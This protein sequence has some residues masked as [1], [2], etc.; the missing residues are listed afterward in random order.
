MQVMHLSLRLLAAPLISLLLD[1]VVPEESVMQM[2]SHEVAPEQQVV[3]ESSDRAKRAVHAIEWSPGKAVH[4]K[5]SIDQ[6]QSQATRVSGAA[7]IPGKLLR[8]SGHSTATA[9]VEV[10][11]R[12]RNSTGPSTRSD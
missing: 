12:S 1:M 2:S 5:Y 8:S 9:L 7:D 4:F 3:P 10:S 11:T 6:Q